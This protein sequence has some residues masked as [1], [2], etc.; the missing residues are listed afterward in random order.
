M[1]KPGKQYKQRRVSPRERVLQGILVLGL[2]FI[3]YQGVAFLVTRGKEPALAQNATQ[4]VGTLLSTVNYQAPGVPT[5]TVRPSPTL[6]VETRTDNTQIPLTTSTPEGL[7]L[8]PAKNYIPD[9][10]TQLGNYSLDSEQA[11]DIS[12]MRGNAYQVHFTNSYP[13]YHDSDDAFSV[14]YIIYVF[15]ETG[16]TDDFYDAFTMD[17]IISI[18]ESTYN[19]RVYPT[20]IDRAVES[21]DAIRMYCFNFTGTTKPEIHCQVLLLDDNL[22]GQI[23]IKIFNTGSSA[24]KAISQARYF[25]DLLVENLK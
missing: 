1:R 11:M 3:V 24:T 23:T 5:N 22:F 17:S 2:L 8:L 9:L 18:Y 25:T 19:Q 13:L 14:T 21:I 12:T 10:P 15:A 16:S 4:I 7:Y 6:M 20:P